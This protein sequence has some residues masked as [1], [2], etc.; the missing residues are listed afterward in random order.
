MSSLTDLTEL[1]EN[2]KRFADDMRMSDYD[3]IDAIRKS[4][5]TPEKIRK[6]QSDIAKSLNKLIGEI[7]YDGSFPLDTQITAVVE[8][9]GIVIKNVIF[10]SR[11][12]VYV[13]SNLYMPRSFSGKLPG[14]LLQCGHSENGKAYTSYQIAA[15]IIA[16]AGMAV[17]AIDPPGQGERVEYTEN[18]KTV[19]RGATFNH[20]QAG[21]Q[22]FL[23][24]TVPI[25]YF[26]CDAMRGIDLLCSL[27]E[28]DSERIGATGIS[29]GGTL[30][31]YLMS[32]DDRIKAA[33]PGCWPSDG[34]EYYAVGTAPDC[35]QIIPNIL[36]YG[37][38]ACE[39][40]ACR[41]PMPLI[42]LCARH[43]Y[44]PFDGVVKLYNETARLY[45]IAGK[46]DNVE[47]CISDTPHGYSA[48]MAES[49]AVFFAKHL[50]GIGYK[51]AQTAYTAAEDT[52][53]YCTKSG[54]V[55]DD[56]TD[57]M[58]TYMENLAKYNKLSEI[59]PSEDQIYS[60][61]HDHVFNK[62]NK[63]TEIK[64][65]KLKSVYDDGLYVQPYVW[66]T[67][68]KMQ[69]CGMMFKNAELADNVLPITV[70]LWSCGTDI[71]FSNA[72]KIREI[73]NSGR[74]AF[75]VDLTA[76]GK[77]SPHQLKNGGDPNEYRSSPTD[78]IAKSL[79]MSGDSLCALDAFDLLMTV[80]MI[81]SEFGTEDIELYTKGIMCIF[82]R[83]AGI[84]DKSLK[85]TFDS[86]VK[87]SDI[88]KN[89]YYNTYDIPRIIIPGIGRYLI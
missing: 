4:V 23:T 50:C 71:L 53:L 54:I 19:I 85:L 49:A 86:E 36:K 84:L 25:S 83:I 81:K 16:A 1:K 46:R 13:T 34:R 33:A 7:P 10:R 55:H 66:S 39:I 12:N 41:L 8:E 30:T 47:L 64:P 76:M 27:D 37:I 35:E 14:I 79:I 20:Q 87:V 26:L 67:Q 6:Y 65:K 15:K 89:K 52:A 22:C 28:V 45:G 29:G 73:C 43:D 74:A 9:D 40:M 63:N 88:I 21:T 42:F 11:E 58:T 17:L 69:C 77:C 5:D 70:C 31:S 57:S 38:D 2:A 82:G 32:I 60:F 24:G 18:G 75:V 48:V 80:K 51:P 56:Y 68:D 3:R 72:E 78:K 59:K 62:R 61:M 44:V